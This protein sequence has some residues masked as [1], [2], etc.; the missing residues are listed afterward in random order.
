MTGPVWSCPDVPIHLNPQVTSQIGELRAVATIPSTP[1]TSAA[2]G[3]DGRSANTN[4][5]RER[6]KW[7]TL[8]FDEGGK[9][10]RPD[11]YI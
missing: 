6:Q 3:D 7:R 9:E 1:G 8:F 5:S 2:M 4:S 10:G 11:V